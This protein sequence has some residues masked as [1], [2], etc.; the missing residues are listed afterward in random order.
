MDP[1]TLYV[2]CT[3]SAV[4]AHKP[5]PVFQGNRIVV[6]L[7]R[8]PLVTLSAAITAYVEAHGDDEIHKNQLCTPVPFPENLTGYAR[9]TFMSAMNQVQW[10]QDKPFRQ[11]MRESRLDAFGKMVSE[12][13]KQAL[14]FRL[15][16]NTLSAMANMAT[17]MA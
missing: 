11:W 7:L 5:Q 6:Q 3:A 17:L 2:D 9:A 13:E 1:H 10:S 8:M 4:K 14:L 16:A 15:R 12:V